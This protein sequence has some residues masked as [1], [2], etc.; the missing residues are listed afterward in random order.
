MKQLLWKEIKIFGLSNMWQSVPADFLKHKHPLILL[1]SLILQTTL[2]YW[3][4]Y[5]S[6]GSAAFMLTQR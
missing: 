3:R 1:L 4:V 6:Q 5:T 2:M